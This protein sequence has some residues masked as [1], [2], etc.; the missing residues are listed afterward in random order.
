MDIIGIDLFD[1]NVGMACAKIR[2]WCSCISLVLILCDLNVGMVWDSYTQM[3]MDITGIDLFDQNMTQIFMDI[4]DIDLFDQIV[5][6]V[7]AKVRLW[8]SW[9]SLV[10]IYLV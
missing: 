2:L 7:C 4:T 6:M 3:L 10:L 9:I 5:G 8:C 1:Q